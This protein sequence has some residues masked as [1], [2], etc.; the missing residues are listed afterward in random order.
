MGGLIFI[1]KYNGAFLRPS[2]PHPM[3]GTISQSEL[4]A[5]KYIDDGTVAVSVDL[6]SCLITATEHRRPFIS[7]QR[8]EHMLPSQNDLLQYYREDTEE[9][10]SV[11]NMVINKSKTFG[12]RFNR[13]RN[14][15]FPLALSFSDGTDVAVSS[16]HKLLGLIIT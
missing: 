15:D 11:N 14:W 1:I 16:E 7:D 10:T 5:V 9:F 6:K 13:S 3:G 4:E 8:T 2:I 12:M